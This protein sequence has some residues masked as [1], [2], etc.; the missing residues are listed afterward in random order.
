MTTKKLPTKKGFYAMS[1][2]NK[3]FS[4][5]LLTE[6]EWQT[7]ELSDGS[8]IDGSFRLN[9][10]NPTWAWYSIISLSEWKYI[11]YLGT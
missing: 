2:D 10:G 6:N 4:I 5:Y 3:E 8:F 1:E 11:H 9:F 7:L